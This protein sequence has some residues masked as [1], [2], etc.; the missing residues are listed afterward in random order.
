M[1]IKDSDIPHHTKLTKAIFDAFEQEMVSLTEE[2][3]VSFEML[4]CFYVL[5]RTLDRQQFLAYASQV[6][7]GL[8]LILLAT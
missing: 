1:D 5:I 7:C 6:I 4:L 3:Q 2:M 8:I